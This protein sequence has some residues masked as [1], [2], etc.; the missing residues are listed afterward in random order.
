[1]LLSLLVTQQ[2]PDT[3]DLGVTFLGL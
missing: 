1:L 3:P 2:S